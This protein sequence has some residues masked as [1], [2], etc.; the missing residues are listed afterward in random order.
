MSG[1]PPADLIFTA[2]P[3][4]DPADTRRTAS[5]DVQ[6]LGRLVERAYECHAA[7]LLRL[8][9]A[10]SRNPELARDAVQEAFLRYHRAVA[11]GQ[12]IA[13]VRAWLAR[14]VINHLRDDARR[15]SRLESISAVRDH[16]GQW[17]HAGSG[18]QL[19]ERIEGLLSRR[20]FECVLLRMQG[21]KYLEI[22]EIL[23]LSPGSVASLFSRAL[24]KL[25]V[26]LTGR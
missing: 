13:N 18:Q 22:A 6:P 17:E 5:A 15:R 9:L 12:A 8:A 21:Y 16:A 14:V 7:Q 23:S 2:M 1:E 19:L 10:E 26:L 20:E 4:D 25:E 24:R 11:A 3:A